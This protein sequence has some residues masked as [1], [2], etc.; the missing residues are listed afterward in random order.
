M[1]Y[2]SLNSRIYDIDKKYIHNVDFGTKF[3]SECDNYIQKNSKNI[4]CQQVIL[5]VKE[6]CLSV[7]EEALDQ[8]KKQLP[9]S[10]ICLKI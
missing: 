6:R 9:A 7:L 2:K 3:Q 1:L 5:D 10:K 4:N 8:V